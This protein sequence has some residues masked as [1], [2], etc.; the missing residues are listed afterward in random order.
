MEKNK[1]LRSIIE[2]PSFNLLAFQGMIFIFFLLAGEFVVQELAYA[3]ERNYDSLRLYQIIYTL[4]FG[5]PAVLYTLI[6][7]LINLLCR[8]YFFVLWHKYII[9]CHFLILYILF[10]RLM[11]PLDYDFSGAPGLAVVFLFFCA[12][13]SILLFS[14]IPLVITF[15]IEQI[16]GIRIESVSYQDNKFK[17][18]WVIFC[19]IFPVVFWAALAIYL[20]ILFI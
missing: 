14:I 3:G 6:I 16:R 12:I 20:L 8:K 7:F 5:A 13:L 11:F 10:R 15:I 1:F 9:L 4:A 2:R 19:A 17:L 18:V